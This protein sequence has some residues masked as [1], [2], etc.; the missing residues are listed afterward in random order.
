[1]EVGCPKR[2]RVFVYT[3]IKRAAGIGDKI[4]DILTENAARVLAGQPPTRRAA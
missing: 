4:A 2:I 1:L 3:Q